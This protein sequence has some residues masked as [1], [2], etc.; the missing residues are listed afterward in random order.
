MSVSIRGGL[1][2]DCIDQQPH[3]VLLLDEIEKAL[4][5]SSISFCR[6]WITASSRSTRQE[7]RF[8]QRRADHDHECRRLGRCERVHRLDAV[9]AKARD[10]EAIK[11]LFTPEFRNRL[12]ATIVSRRVR[13]TRSTGW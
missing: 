12:D 1:L 2:T 4:W 11:R 6:G 10:E 5:T 13:A 7:D 8:P 9:N 3:S